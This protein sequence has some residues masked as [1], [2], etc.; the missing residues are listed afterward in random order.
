MPCVDS[1]GKLSESGRRMLAAL[2]SSPT[3]EEVAGKTGLPLY[4][5]RSGTREFV[6]AGLAEVKDGAYVITAAGRTLLETPD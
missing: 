4:R 2:A 3:L 6:H 5:V 1:S